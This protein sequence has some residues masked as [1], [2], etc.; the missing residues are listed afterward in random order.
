MKG[1]WPLRAPLERGAVLLRARE[2]PWPRGIQ[3]PRRRQPY[4][5]GRT[6]SRG[7]GRRDLAAVALDD[8]PRQVEPEAGPLPHLPRGE[9][10]VED[11]RQ[12]VGVDPRPAV[13]HGDADAASLGAGA[14]GDRPAVAHRPQRIVEEV[15]QDLVERSGPGLGRAGELEGGGDGGGGGGRAGRAREYTSWA[16][17]TPPEATSSRG[18]RF[19]RNGTQFK[20]AFTGFSTSCA[21]PAVSVPTIAIFSDCASCRDSSRIRSWALTRARSSRGLKGFPT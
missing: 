2:I 18:S 7:R 4:G 1:S 14:H 13:L 15:H 6:L 19:S 5:E 16:E 17:V 3:R 9:E 11:A 8:P 12:D 10:R 21:S 20:M